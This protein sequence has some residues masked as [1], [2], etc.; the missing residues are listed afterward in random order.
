[1]AAASFAR[2]RP[3]KKCDN[4]S[5]RRHRTGVRRVKRKRRRRVPKAEH[6]QAKVEGEAGDE[7]PET[8]EVDSEDR[9]SQEQAEAEAARRSDEAS[10]FPCT[11]QIWPRLTEKQASLQKWRKT[12]G[13]RRGRVKRRA[14]SQRK[15]KRSIRR[16]GAGACLLVPVSP[17]AFP[18]F[19]GVLTKGASPSSPGRPRLR[20][21]LAF[22]LEFGEL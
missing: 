7:A 10:T 5:R 3:G 14:A 18:P 21:R 22:D 8:K 2:V 19:V 20:P 15:T 11:D 12:R 9:K 1:M 17:S 16:T 6:A 4:I 13:K